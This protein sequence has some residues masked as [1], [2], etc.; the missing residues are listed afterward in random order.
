MNMPAERLRQT[1]HDMAIAMLKKIDLFMKYWLKL[2][3]TSNYLRNRLSVV[4]RA[5]TLY[6][7]YS[8]HKLNF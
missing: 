8:K 6:E 2:I 4:G 7:I 3:F 5:I 1:L